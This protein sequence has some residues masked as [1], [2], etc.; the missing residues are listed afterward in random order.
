[1]L[2]ERNERDLTVKMSLSFAWGCGFRTPSH[3]CRIYKIRVRRAL[4][5]YNIPISNYLYLV[6]IFL[7]FILQQFKRGLNKRTATN[8]KE[9]INMQTLSKNMGLFSRRQTFVLS[10][11]TNS[12]V[13]LCCM[14]CMRIITCIR[15]LRNKKVCN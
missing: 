1:M 11:M 14:R 4:H 9:L 10:R 12:K 3:I 15:T 5:I 2:S 7:Y 6:H 13:L 8:K